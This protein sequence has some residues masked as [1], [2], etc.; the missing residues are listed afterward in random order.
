MKVFVIPY[1]EKYIDQFIK[2]YKAYKYHF[3]NYHIKLALAFDRVD[4][5]EKDFKTITEQVDGTIKH[6]VAPRNIVIT[7]FNNF[8]KKVFSKEEIERLKVLRE[9]YKNMGIDV[10]V[11]DY[12]DA[13]TIEE[14]ESASKKIVDLAN[15]ISMLKLSPL[16]NLL[17]AY[18]MVADRDYIAEKE[19]ESSSKSRSVYSILNNEEIVCAGYSTYLKTLADELHDPNVKVFCNMV[20]AKSIYDPYGFHQNNIAY[21]KDDKYGIDGFFYLDPTWD[22]DELQNLEDI[23][24]NFFMLPIGEIKHM[25]Y[26]ISDYLNTCAEY[27][28]DQEEYGDDEEGEENNEEQDE[29]DHSKSERRVRDKRA[30]SS[31]LSLPLYSSLSNSTFRLEILKKYSKYSEESLYSYLTSREDFQKFSLNSYL[32]VTSKQFRAADIKRAYWYSKRYPDKFY[33]KIGLRKMWN[34]MNRHSHYIDMSQVLGALRQVLKANFPYTDKDEISKVVFDIAQ[35]NIENSKG[36]FTSESQAP[37]PM[38]NYRVQNAQKDEE[39]KPA[40]TQTQESVELAEA[41]KKAQKTVES[42]TPEME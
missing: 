6:G 4:L 39:N 10:R 3:R 42:E 7:F 41:A 17:S 12:K 29:Q 21:L 36:Y 16:E 5:A 30:S 14:V 1:E 34:F 2:A 11:Y 20:A 27:A 15:E 31:N 23:K 37:F 28:E 22:S 24:L 18:L 32:R 33:G 19:G 40:E 13:Y 35:K 26:N 38:A 25:G 8:S 9:G